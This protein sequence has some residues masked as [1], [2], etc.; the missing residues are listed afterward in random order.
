M[1]WSS[2]PCRLFKIRRFCLTFPQM[3]RYTSTFRVRESTS[4]PVLRCDRRSNSV[5]RVGGKCCRPASAAGRP[6]PLGPPLR[7]TNPR[8][9][10][11][12]TSTFSN[13]VSSLGS[14]YAILTRSISSLAAL[15]E[16]NSARAPLANHDLSRFFC[17]TAHPGGFVRDC[18][19]RHTSP[20]EG[21]KT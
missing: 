13:S 9:T 6:R 8:A 14:P 5:S 12:A 2:T 21:F 16:L 4:R 10:S 19:R 7:E 1:S 20:H 11:A 18:S 3:N 15:A 17:A